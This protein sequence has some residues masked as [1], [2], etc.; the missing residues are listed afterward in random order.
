MQRGVGGR[1]MRKMACFSP[2]RWT[3]SRKSM[4]GRG[5]PV[6]LCR[7]PLSF[8]GK[9]LRVYSTSSSLRTKHV[10]YFPTR[11]RP[12]RTELGFQIAAQEDRAADDEEG[13]IQ[14]QQVEV[15]LAHL[16]PRHRA[17]EKIHPRHHVG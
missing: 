9:P 2:E 10:A 17:A 16:R 15:V 8:S 7:K 5:K 13:G 11:D 3:S 6:S 4:S 14:S 1:F 12:K